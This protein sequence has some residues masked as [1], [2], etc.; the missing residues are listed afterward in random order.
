VRIGSAEVQGDGIGCCAEAAH[1]SGDKLAAALEVEHVENAAI[2]GCP[3]GHP[4]PA[5]EH[6]GQLWLVNPLDIDA[7]HAVDEGGVGDAVP[8]VAPG[9]VVFVDVGRGG[10]VDGQGIAAVC[11]QAEDEDVAASIAPTGKSDVPAPWPP[12][13]LGVGAG[14]EG[15]AQRAFAGSASRVGTDNVD[16]QVLGIV[17]VAL[18]GQE[19]SV[20]TPGGRALE[21]RRIGQSGDGPRV[22][23]H[24]VQ[25]PVAVAPAGEGQARPVR[26]PGRIAVVGGAVGQAERVAFADSDHPDVVLPVLAQRVGQAAAGAQGVGNGR[27]RGQR[28]GEERGRHGRIRRLRPAAAP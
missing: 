2:V 19:G 9:G 25:F 15:S 14:G 26:R 10:Q 23:L 22:H 11:I 5:N 1:R 16:V 6:R 28:R 13:R 3:G 18:V 8:I 21:A 17:V 4:P 12:G 27:G 7:F 20:W 24:D